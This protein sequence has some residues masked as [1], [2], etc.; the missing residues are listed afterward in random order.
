MAG[1]PQEVLAA[2]LRRLHRSAG[3]PGTRAIAK[4]IKFSH[5]TVAQALNGSRCPKW[6]AI[7]AMV[8]HLDGDVE[9]FRPLWQ[10]VR[11]A[12]SPIPAPADALP[13]AQPSGEAGRSALDLRTHTATGDALTRMGVLDVFTVTEDAA[14]EMSR[15]LA[16][17]SLAEV[18]L[19]GLSL[20]S[21]FGGRGHRRGADWPGQ[22]LERMLLGKEPGPARPGGI[23]VRVLLLDP[24]C[25]GLR[26]LTYGAGSD[27]GAE[28]ERLRNEIR[29]TAEH[30]SRLGSDVARRRTG[31][32]LQLRFSR[33][34]PPFFLFAAQQSAFMRSYYHGLATD[35][36]APAA[37]AVW[38]FSAES[39]AYQATCRHFDTIW[40]T[41]SVPAEELLRHKS[42][43]MDQ[44]IS[45]SGIVN[46]YTNR[47]SA[48][49]HAC[50]DP[51]SRQRPGE[52]QVLSRLLARPG[53]RR[54]DRLRLSGIFT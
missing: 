13:T 5:T 46:I 40:D 2:E 10:A 11:D 49:R 26:L 27:A 15:T 42:I 53:G 14:A 45:E 23:R 35:P 30:L 18:R 44:G 41:D 38:H 17:P 8:R 48:C 50:A 3:E 22:R 7:E 19:L 21:W 25:L 1:S 43:G 28:L 37:A 54:G 32:S 51:R 6:N 34:V 4:A 20:S 9:A 12:E 31:D 29:E 52:A 39:L 47:E 16:D 24:A 36:R 33:A